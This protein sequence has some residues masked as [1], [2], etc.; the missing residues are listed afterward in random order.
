M[1]YLKVDGDFD[2]E[3][4]LRDIHVELTDLNQEAVGLA[5]KIKKNFE[6]MGI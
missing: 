3:Q 4:V 2:F 6:G 1:Q 5:A